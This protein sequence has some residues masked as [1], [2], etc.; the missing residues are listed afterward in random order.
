MS[1][2]LKDLI[3]KFNFELVTEGLSLEKEIEGVYIS[4]LLSW[5]MGKA[6]EN[7][8]WITIQGHINI[9]AVA[10]LV[11]V[12]CIIIAESSEISIDTIEKAVKEEIPIFKT[13]LTEYEVAKKFVEAGV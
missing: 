9:V 13:E 7:C 3:T 10:S 2:I 8:A 6:E 4:D 11:G 5:V 1:I 12:S